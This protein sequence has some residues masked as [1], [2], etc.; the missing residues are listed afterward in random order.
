VKDIDL[1][2]ILILAAAACFGWLAW[3]QKSLAWLGAAL[4]VVGVYL[5]GYLA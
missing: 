1:A 5:T 4:L 2:F 3:K